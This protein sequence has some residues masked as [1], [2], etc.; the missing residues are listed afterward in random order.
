MKKG[1]ILAVIII[2]VIIAGIIIFNV[3]NNGDEQNVTMDTQGE[4]GYTVEYQGV[5]VTPGTEFNEN[6]IS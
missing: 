6:A 2:A 1:I 5:N 4:E 3:I